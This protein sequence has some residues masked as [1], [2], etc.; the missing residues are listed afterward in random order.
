MIFSDYFQQV[1]VE[2]L[3]ELV[4]GKAVYGLF[5]LFPVLVGNK[6]RSVVNGKNYFYIDAVFDLLL[7]LGSKNGFDK[8]LKR[9]FKLRFGSVIARLNLM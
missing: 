8:L 2:I 6:L 5:G 3:S 7:L 4:I 9:S 1:Y